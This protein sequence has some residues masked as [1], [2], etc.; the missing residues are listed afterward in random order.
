MPVTLARLELAYREAMEAWRRSLDDKETRSETGGAGAAAEKTCVRRT[1]QSGQAALL[2]T[3]IHAAKEVYTFKA[4]HLARRRHAEAAEAERIR[5]AE[6]AEAERVREEIAGELESLHHTDLEE[7]RE[8]VLDTSWETEA[9]DPEELAEAIN[10]LPGEEYRKL[11][12]RCRYEPMRLPFRRT[13]PWRVRPTKSAEETS[14][15]PDTD[16]GIPDSLPSGDEAAG[17]ATCAAARHPQAGSREA[18]AR[19][20]PGSTR[21]ARL[22]RKVAIPR[23]VGMIP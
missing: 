2:R 15:P 17:G 10:A 12:E 20:P 5:A 9:R 16:A 3:V 6:A 4:G 8:I 23:I 11:W 7:T 1:T 19:C 18:G 14:D 22:G 21:L 13:T